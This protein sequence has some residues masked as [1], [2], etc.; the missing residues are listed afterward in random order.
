MAY[1]RGPDRP[2]LL[3]WTDAVAHFV[4]LAPG[5][6][7]ELPLDQLIHPDDV[8]LP[9]A[10]GQSVRLRWRRSGPATWGWVQ[11]QEQKL[12]LA[13]SPD[14]GGSP[15]VLGVVTDIDDLLRGPAAG[16][17]VLAQALHQAAEVRRRLLRELN[18]RIKNN[19]QLVASLLRLQAFSLTDPAVQA[20]F[21]QTYQRVACLADIHTGLYMTETVADLDFG[22]FVLT[23][24]ERLP[25]GLSAVPAG[26]RIAMQA[27]PGLMLDVDRAVP[28][29]LVLNELLSNALLH[30]TAAGG[31]VRSGVAVTDGVLRLWVSDDGVDTRSS[32]GGSGA[33]PRAASGQL[34]LRLVR[35]LVSQVAGQLHERQEQG[36]TIEVTLSLTAVSP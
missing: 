18:H 20:L 3:D 5:S 29:G 32:A 17:T 10:D 4:G 14:G 13:A 35:A 28:L 9:M 22:A 31:V 23:L 8:N 6:A 33:D 26:S 11:I 19:L 25:R 16:E 2:A 36:R 34:G 21:D 30:G 7:A 15:L 12:P 27:R 1:L 24:A